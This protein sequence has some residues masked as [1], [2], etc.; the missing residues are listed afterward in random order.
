VGREKDSPISDQ[1]A[2]E[3]A[4]KLAPVQHVT[5]GQLILALAMFP[6][7]AV[8]ILGAMK[9]GWGFEYTLLWIAG[10]SVFLWWHYYEVSKSLKLPW[11]GWL[12]DYVLVSLLWFALPLFS[13]FAFVNMYPLPQAE[14]AAFAAG[15]ADFVAWLAGF[16]FLRTRQLSLNDPRDIVVIYSYTLVVAAGT[17][18]AILS[19]PLW[20]LMALGW[21]NLYKNLPLWQAAF[22]FVVTVGFI[23]LVIEDYSHSIHYGY[24]PTLVEV[25]GKKLIAHIYSDTYLLRSGFTWSGYMFAQAAVF[26]AILGFLRFLY[27]KLK[28]QKSDIPV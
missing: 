7:Q 2:N 21:V 1:G 20:W 13:V 12:M 8:M 11:V 26:S 27:P 16:E 14:L 19:A 3:P 5:W 15:H 4:G 28:K 10:V 22:I 6:A 23:V 9:A 24:K 18:G 25:G 17:W